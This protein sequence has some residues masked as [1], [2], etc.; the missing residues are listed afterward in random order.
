MEQVLIHSLDYNQRTD[1]TVSLTDMQISWY[2][3]Y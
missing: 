2:L 3:P 1:K